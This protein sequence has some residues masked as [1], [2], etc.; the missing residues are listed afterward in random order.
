MDK[1]TKKKCHAVI[2]SSSAA[3]AGVGGGLAQIPGSDSPIL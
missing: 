1:S 2:H 3:A